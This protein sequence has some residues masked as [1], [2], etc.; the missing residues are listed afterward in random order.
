VIAIVLLGIYAYLIYVGCA[1]VT[2]V[3]TVNCS[4]FTVSAFNDV[5]AQA[6]SVIGGLVSAFIIAVLA[7]TKTGDAPVGSAIA[8]GVSDR[9]KNLL[10]WV[11]G[12]YILVW[13]VAGLSAFMVGMFHPS[14][15]PALTNV[16]QSWLGLAVAAAYAY[17]GLSPAESR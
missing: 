1:T 9:A 8:Q 10:K 3:N 16:G 5:M 11:S 14:T 12:A 4:T 13:L 2:C 15:L 17:F 7:V 6:L